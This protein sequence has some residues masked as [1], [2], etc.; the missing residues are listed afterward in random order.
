MKLPA[1]S[2]EL[3][4]ILL[5]LSA[6]A[7]FGLMDGISKLLTGH[8]PPTQILFLR[9]LLSIPVAVLLAS[10]IGLRTA[11]HTHRPFFQLARVV[12]IVVEMVLVLFAYRLMPLANA[13]AIFAATPLIVVAL[14]VPVLGEKVGLRR[15]IAVLIGFVGV[16]IAVRPGPDMLT[17]GAIP[18]L[19]ATGLYAVY[20]LMTR[21]VTRVDRAETT[22]LIQIVA[23]TALQAPFVPFVWVDPTPMHWPLFAA[24]AALGAV[25]HLMLIHALQAAP[26]AVVQPFTYSMLLWA[27]LVGWL[28]FG[29]LPD[30]WTISGGA[31]VVA[32]GLYAAVR[33]QRLRNEERSALSAADSRGAT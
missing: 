33:E 3:R 10:R 24:I 31:L 18:T 4:G 22:F 20:Q 15:W 21:I 6:M 12:I 30:A 19:I 5:V 14:S 28:F 11:L 7:M 16:L 13:H 8:Y 25:S 9:Y 32:A 1:L 29:D 26:A 27:T 17:S 2:G 23:G